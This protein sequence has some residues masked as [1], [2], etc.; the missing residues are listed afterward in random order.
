MTSP[1]S[2]GGNQ[3]SDRV[4]DMPG[5]TQ[6]KARVQTQAGLMPDALTAVPVTSL[7]GAG[8]TE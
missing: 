1:L 5:V 8:G 3:D 6:A 4:S 7:G 2:R